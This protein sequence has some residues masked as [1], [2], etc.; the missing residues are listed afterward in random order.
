MTIDI[1]AFEKCIGH[2]TVNNIQNDDFIAVYVQ[3]YRTAVAMALVTMITQNELHLNDTL[4][5]I[6]FLRKGWMPRRNRT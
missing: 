5:V 2:S 1:F 3:C 6:F 4:R